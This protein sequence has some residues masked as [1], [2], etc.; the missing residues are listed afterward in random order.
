MGI[1]F[2]AYLSLCVYVCVSTCVYGQMYDVT[3]EVRKWYQTLE[4]D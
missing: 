1:F 2:L 3:T 4:T